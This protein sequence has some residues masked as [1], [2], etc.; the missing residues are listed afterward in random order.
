MIT[1]WYCNYRVPVEYDLQLPEQS[2]NTVEVV[3]PIHK[4]ESSLKFKE[5][6]VG[7]LSDT[8]PGSVTFKKRKNTGA[9]KKN[10]RQ[11]FTDDDW[12]VTFKLFISTLYVNFI[13]NK[14]KN[15]YFNWQNVYSVSE[16][17]TKIIYFFKSLIFFYIYIIRFFFNN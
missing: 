17:K 1:Y 2:E 6:V 10:A 5:K 4:E 8:E 12:C 3:I 7:S 16:N 13:S 9:L 14:I 15:F 11:R